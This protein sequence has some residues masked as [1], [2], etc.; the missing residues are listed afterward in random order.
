MSVFFR[1]PTVVLYVWRTRLLFRFLF[2]GFQ[3]LLISMV[4]RRDHRIITNVSGVHAER[5]RG[6]N[7][8]L[9]PDRGF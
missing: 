4:A 8:R 6:A 5:F 2:A 3:I 1:Q 9:R 7:I